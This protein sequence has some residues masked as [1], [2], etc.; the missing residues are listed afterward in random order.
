VPVESLIS[1]AY[2]QSR[3]RLIDA[4]HAR[5]EESPGQPQTMSGNTVYLS[6]VDREGNIASLIQSVYQHFGS[7]VVV[8]DYG[9]AL[10]NRGGLFELDPA[11]PNALAPR[12]RPYHTINPAFM[13]K[14]DVHIGFG[15]MGGL[16]QTPAHAQFVSNVVDHGMSIQM[17]LEAPRFTKL[18]FGGCDV[19]IE[20]R[21]TPQVRDALKAKG[22]ELT[23]TG[24]FSNQ[25]GGGQAVIY[26]SATGV[27]YGA[28][29]PRKDG[30][31]VPEPHPYYK[32]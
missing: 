31:A 7:G 13:E 32:N 8:D 3:A 26:N 2:A 29:D 24:D 9:F 14:G 1:P 16:N 21:V 17:A 23:V 20:N 4:S 28:S 19:L 10:Q 25:M 12:K 18:K 22:H 15:I 11:H 6:V 27:K 30:A 5:C